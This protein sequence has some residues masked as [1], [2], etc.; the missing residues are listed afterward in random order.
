M[1]DGRNIE[2]DVILP[3]SGNTTPGPSTRRGGHGLN[4][5]CLG[6]WEV[7]TERFDDALHGIAEPLVDLLLRVRD[8]HEQTSGHADVERFYISITSLS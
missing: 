6:V 3:R 7:K 4:L 2:M 1:H 8:V 5:L